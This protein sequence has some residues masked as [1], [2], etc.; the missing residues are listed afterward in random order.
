MILEFSGEVARLAC[1]G[2]EARISPHGLT[3]GGVPISIEPGPDGTLWC[4]EPGADRVGR[5]TTGAGPRPSGEAAFV[6][7]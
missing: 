1:V 4:A 3:V 7:A 5:V 2:G 6:P